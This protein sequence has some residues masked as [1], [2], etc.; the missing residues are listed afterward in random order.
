MKVYQLKLKEFDFVLEPVFKTEKG[1]YLYKNKYRDRE[2][3]IEELL[4]DK[5]YNED[6]IYRIV[7]KDS[8]GEF[9]EEKIFTNIESAKV[10]LNNKKYSDAKIVKEF[11]SSENKIHSELIEL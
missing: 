2:I 6:F 4:I 8:E 3:K 10:F 9:L 1:A 7:N 11:F 5:D